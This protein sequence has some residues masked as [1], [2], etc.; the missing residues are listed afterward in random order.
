MQPC[1]G[2]REAQQSNPKQLENLPT[3][4][5]NNK[6]HP[7][8]MDKVYGNSDRSSKLQTSI[9]LKLLTVFSIILQFINSC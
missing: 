9:F 6:V 3:D 7:F 8:V 5:P 1:D 4:N 2:I